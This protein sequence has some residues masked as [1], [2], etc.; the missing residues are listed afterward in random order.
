[1]ILQ[2]LVKDYERILRYCNPVDDNEEE[3]NET[4]NSLPAMYVEKP[5]RW[6]IVLDSNGKLE[7]IVPLS[8]GGKKER[9][10]PMPVPSVVRTVNI[11]PLLFA[12]TP[13][14]VLG[15]G[16]GDKEDKNIG[17][18]HQ[19]FS[20]LVAQCATATGLPEVKAIQNFLEQ[21]SNPETRPIVDIPFDPSDTLIFEVD[22]QEVTALTAIQKFWATYSASQQNASQPLYCLICGNFRPALESMPILLKRIPGGQP[23]GTALVSAN[24]DVFE[25]YGLTRATT[26]PICAECAEKFCKSL[27]AL[28]ASEQMS[29]RVA[30]SLV[31]VF[32]SP[33]KGG[34]V[35]VSNLRQPDPAWVKSLLQSY[36]KRE[37]RRLK[38]R[39]EF[40]ALALSANMA[41]AVVR[42]WLTTTIGHAEDNLAQWFAWQSIIDAYGQENKPLSLFRLA[43]SL[44]RKPEDIEDEVTLALSRT[45]LH[46]DSLPLSMLNSAVM[47][48][49]AEASASKLRPERVITYER[50]ALMTLIL[51]SRQRFDNTKE[52]SLLETPDTTVAL[53]DDYRAQVC[54]RLLAI[55]EKL[56][57]EQADNRINTTLVDRFYG[58]AST[59][60]A[61][62]FGTLLSDAQP[63]LAKLRKKNGG[64]YNRYQNLLETLLSRLDKYPTT[65][66]VKQQALF[67]LGYYHQRAELRAAAIA[68]KEAKNARIAA[69]QDDN[70]QLELVSK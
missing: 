68:G 65:L 67:S 66:S 41:R 38:N 13:A 21:W 11:A 42:D 56:Q 62:V 4:S 19:A 3:E 37:R 5:V 35:V 16:T 51:R 10:K 30:N 2:Q 52:N 32:W 69:E 59:A 1:M 55:L 22:G 31:Y 20:D 23:A 43:V 36:H 28:L 24:S 39:S 12:D 18:K 53:T 17:K 9:G 47:R 25:S 33:S 14:Y 58:A 48:C 29:L 15:I 7:G 49:R 61:T 8:G 45:A 44:Y 26:S 6:K 34:E 40:Y 50:A 60:P 63:H 54:G 70:D 46:G 64:A 57:E 27:N